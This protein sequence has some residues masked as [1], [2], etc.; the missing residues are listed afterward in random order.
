M[1]Y[2]KHIRSKEPVET[3]HTTGYE[4]EE[5]YLEVGK[6]YKI[7]YDKPYNKKEEKNNG[8]TVEIL[9]FSDYSFADAIVRYDDNNRIGRVQVNCMLPLE[10]YIEQIKNQKG[11]RPKINKTKY[12][13]LDR[14]NFWEEI[15]S[16]EE[17]PDGIWVYLKEGYDFEGWDSGTLSFDNVKGVLKEVKK[18]YI[19][20]REEG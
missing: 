14:Y 7:L 20:K 8:R 4:T 17:D 18:K 9:G 15:E 3:W 19:V 5:V 11:K 10:S 13:T 2:R 16:I 12:K 1:E 6:T